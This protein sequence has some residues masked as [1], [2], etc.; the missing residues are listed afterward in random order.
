VKDLLENDCNL[1]SDESKINISPS[2]WLSQHGAYSIF[3]SPKMRK[4]ENAAVS[5]CFNKQAAESIDLELAQSKC[6]VADGVTLETTG[7]FGWKAVFMGSQEAGAHLTYDISIPETHNFIAEGV[8]VH[9]C[10]I[11]HGAS[12]FLREKLFTLSDKYRIHLCDNCGL[13]CEAN[14]KEGTAYCKGCDNNTH[15]SQTSIPY[16]CKLLFQELMAMNISPRIFTSPYIH[17]SFALSQ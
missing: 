2:E 13:I 7:F 8:T 9:N 5:D 16:A 1:D 15:I 6:K 3:N 11:S 17:K 10:M 12:Q 14:I 4:C